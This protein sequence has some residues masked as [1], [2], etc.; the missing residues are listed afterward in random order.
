MCRQAATVEFRNL[1]FGMTLFQGSM[2]H[3]LEKV[4]VPNPF[5]ARVELDGEQA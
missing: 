5:L 2:E 3:L 4:V 1:L